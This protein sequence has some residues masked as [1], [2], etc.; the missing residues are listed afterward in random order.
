MLRNRKEA[1]QNIQSSLDEMFGNHVRQITPVRS[2]GRKARDNK[3]KAVG[4]FRPSRD[5]VDSIKINYAV[6]E[7]TLLEDNFAV[8]RE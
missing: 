8:Y 5:K 6:T 7:W 3:Y 4:M 1:V 2:H